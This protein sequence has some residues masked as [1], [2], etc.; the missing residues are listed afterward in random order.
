VEDFRPGSAGA[1][2]KTGLT[3]GAHASA[4]DRKKAPR[5]E[6]V[7]HRRKRTS[8]ITPTTRVGRAAWASRWVSAYGR[9]EASRSRLGQRPSGPQGRPGRKR[10]KEFFELKIGFLNLSRLWKFAQGDLG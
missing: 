4:V 5:T 3:H 8:A 1:V 2:G 10:R 6:G 7:N 9:G